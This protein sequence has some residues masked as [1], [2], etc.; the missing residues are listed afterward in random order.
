M[1]NIT[2]RYKVD[3]HSIP[4]SANRRKEMSDWCHECVGDKWIHWKFKN[5][6][7]H[8]RFKKDYALFL[9]RWS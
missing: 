4:D 6:K 1:Y 8:F 3:Y 7:W 2:M 5:W 9:L